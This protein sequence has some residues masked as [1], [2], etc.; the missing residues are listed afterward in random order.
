MCLPPVRSA[1]RRFWVCVS[2]GLSPAEAGV[3]VGVS[4]RCGV[5]WFADAGGVRPRLC[6][7]NTCSPRRRL[8]FEDRV[9]IEIGV[10]TNESLQSMGKRAKVEAL[11][12][13]E[14]WTLRPVSSW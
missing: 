14:R 1:V 4:Q 2:Q 6:A 3:V 9:E 5:H 12:P 8:S 11:C 13:P 10:R 7:P